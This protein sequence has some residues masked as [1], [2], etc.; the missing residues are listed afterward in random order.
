MG[1]RADHKTKAVPISVAR[2]QLFA[3]VEALL[4]RR[5]DRVTV[6][7]KARAEEV[8]LLRAADLARLEAEV[9]ALRATA[10]PAPR[11]LRGLG[12]LHVPADQI[13]KETRARQAALAAAKRERLLAPLRKRAAS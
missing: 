13:L 2:T 12:T 5:R 11:P 9:A 4:S 8:V 3:L 1:K 10:A 6:S 7:H